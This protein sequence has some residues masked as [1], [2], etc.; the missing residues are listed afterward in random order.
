LVA[1]TSSSSYAAMMR[2]TFGSNAGTVRSGFG[3]NRA[4]AATSAG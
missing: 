2:L 3:R 4:S 1:I